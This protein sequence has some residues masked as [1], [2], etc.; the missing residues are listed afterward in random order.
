MR[1]LHISDVHLGASFG[2]RSSSAQAALQEGLEEAFRGCVQ[3]ALDRKAHALV[4]AGDLVDGA[5]LSYALERF[6]GEQLHRLGQAGVAIIYALGN[7]D[8]RGTLGPGVLPDGVQ[9]FDAREP[10]TVSVRDREGRFVGTVTG[11]GFEG[12]LEP[13]DLASRFAPPDGRLPSVAVLHTEAASGGGRYA[14]AELGSF[15]A[16]F[17]YWALGHAHAPA[18]LSSRP[19]VQYSGSLQGRSRV[20]TGARGGVFVDLSDQGRPVT[21]FVELAPVRWERLRVDLAGGPRTLDELAEIATRRLARERERDPGLAGARWM[22][23]LELGGPSPLWSRL[24]RAEDLETLGEAVARATRAAE[25]DIRT[26]GVFPKA[27]LNEARRRIDVLGATLELVDELLQGSEELG[28][29]PRE[30]LSYDPEA[31]GSP[32]AY[33]RSLLEGAGEEIHSRMARLEPEGGA[34]L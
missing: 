13:R 22:L 32:Q 28:V 24:R 33:V 27:D 2:A 4:I 5:R 11:A 9:T 18:R 23:E 34:D 14:P 26:E 17:D 15:S 6:L 1:L 25:V 30:L 12:A 19:R 10:R 29:D 20:E 31:D 16:G 8:P 3:T 21:E 7:H